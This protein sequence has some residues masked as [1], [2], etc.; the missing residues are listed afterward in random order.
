MTFQR[1]VLPVLIAS[2]GGVPSAVQAQA[3]RLVV[4]VRHAEAGGEP[5]RNPPLT[6]GGR[7]RAA[8]LATALAGTGIGRIIVT[9]FTRTQATAGPLAAATGV[10]PMVV[11]VTGGLEAHVQSVA[12]AVRDAPAGQAVLVVGHSNTIPAIVTALG[13]PKLADLCHTD[14]DTLFILELRDAAP[15]RLIRAGYGAPDA[16][17]C[18]AG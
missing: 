12:A 14:F 10:T 15:P 18:P 11:E 2:L 1:V 8:A 4:L 16:E 5:E 17:A 9:G 13:G 3:S 7:A 6:D